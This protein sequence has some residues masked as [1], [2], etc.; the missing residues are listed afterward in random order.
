MLKPVRLAVLGRIGRGKK[1]HSYV[2]II[3][4]VESGAKSLSQHSQFE[5]DF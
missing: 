5:S 2:Q 3:A 4:S 1:V